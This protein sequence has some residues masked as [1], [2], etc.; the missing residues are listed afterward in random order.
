MDDGSRY[1]SNSKNSNLAVQFIAGLK[2]E[3]AWLR[4]YVFTEDE[5]SVQK[6]STDSSGRLSSDL[7]YEE[8]IRS[9]NSSEV[10]DLIKTLSENKKE[11]NLK[12]EEIQKSL[13]ETHEILAN[14]ELVGGD[15]SDTLDK[16]NS[17]AD[18]G[19]ALNKTLQSLDIRLKQA[20]NLL[21]SSM[22]RSSKV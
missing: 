14:V 7:D 20:R 6:D 1:N 3:W 17:L 21:N 19:S 12:I 9:L 13:E 4:D 2:E 16:I 15:N 5:N 11:L 18:Q 10:R 22:D 8:K